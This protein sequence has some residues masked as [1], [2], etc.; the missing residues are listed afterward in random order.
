MGVSRFH[1]SGRRWMRSAEEDADWPDP[2]QPL[3]EPTPDIKPGSP[4]L[5]PLPISFPP[6]LSFLSFIKNHPSFFQK[7][8]IT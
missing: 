6:S 3:L 1:R 4:L 5:A 8:Q 7:P 2:G